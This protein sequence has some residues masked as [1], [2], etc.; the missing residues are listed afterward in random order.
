VKE[1]LPARPLNADLNGFSSAGADNG[2][3]HIYLLTAA[4]ALEYFR[5]RQTAIFVFI[6]VFVSS[7][8]YTH[9]D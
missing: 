8:L 3:G 1:L 6:K 7:A 2:D 5:R 9:L 4:P